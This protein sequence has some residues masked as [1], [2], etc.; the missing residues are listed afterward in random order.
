[1]V[2]IPYSRKNRKTLHALRPPNPTGGS[3]QGSPPEAGSGTVLTRTPAL[4]SYDW[5]Q[6]RGITSMGESV[7]VL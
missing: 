1:M 3:H 6:G 7:E 5:I 4:P 2:L